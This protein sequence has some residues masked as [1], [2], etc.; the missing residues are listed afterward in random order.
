VFEANGLPPFAQLFDYGDGTAYLTITPPA[1]VGEYTNLEISVHDIYG[2]SHILPFSINVNSNHTPVITPVAPQAVKETNT[3]QFTLNATDQDNEA[4]TWS[5]QNVPVFMTSTPN[6]NNLDVTMIPL[7]NHA[8]TY[9]ITFTATDVN[10]GSASTIVTINVEDYDPNYTVN[11]NFRS[12]TTA[13]GP[14]DWN[15]VGN[16]SDDTTIPTSALNKTD[17]TS[18]GITFSST[19]QWTR[20]KDDNGVTPGVFPNAVN[21]SLFRI[22]NVTAGE[23]LTLVGLNPQGKYNLKFLSSTKL[24]T[25]YN[26]LA[27]TTFTI[28]G[29]SQ[30]I[31]AVGNASTLVTFSQLT[32]NAS[33]VISINVKTAS[34]AF[35][36]LNAMVIE[37]YFE[38]TTAP[39]A[40]SNLQ[41]ATT[42]A[43][44]I[45]V[46]W[47]DNSGG[48]TSQELYRSTDD[49]NFDKVAT[50]GTDVTSYIDT[51]FAAGNTYYYKVLA[52]NSI[53]TSAF[54]NTGSIVAP[55]RK[56]VILPVSPITLAEQD[57]KWVEV[58]G[59][60]VD[61]DALTF[62]LENEPNFM[63]AEYVDDTKVNLVFS[64]S[65]GEKGTYQFLLHCDDPNGG[66]TT[67]NLSVTVYSASDVEFKI[68]FTQGSSAAAPW[69]NVTSYTTGTAL[70]NLKNSNNIPVTGVSITLVQGWNGSNPNGYNS[71]NNSGIYPDAV[72]S[73]S[74]FTS[75]GAT[76]TVQLA[77]LNPAK[78][79]D[80]T[81][82]AS[83]MGVTDARNAIYTIGTKSAMLNA[84][85]NTSNTA[86]II[87]IKPNA[88]NQISIEVSKDG[89][90]TFGY[91]GAIVVREYETIVVPTVPQAPALLISQVLTRTSIKLD[92]Q[93]ASND[94]TGFEIW[95]S[96][97]NS[98]NYS[99]LTT[100]GAGV[101]TYT[102]TL[103]A[104][105]TST[106]TRLQRAM[107][108]DYLLFQMKPVVQPI[109]IQFQ[110]ISMPSMGMHQ[111]GII[112]HSTRK[113]IQ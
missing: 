45:Q 53:G 84:S 11:V 42:Q 26:N 95:R 103:L 65:L 20:F 77:G 59:T 27:V 82:F 71:G 22:W 51:N 43:D 35:A 12:F 5:V 89:A 33:G 57:M 98:T 109:S 7:T 23:T 13:N 17:G 6:G 49:I 64:P 88:S 63:W 9:N 74:F 21:S 75:D 40:P 16:G 104:T 50:L 38:G 58:T 113:V 79:Y 90:S 69:N 72:M 55:N 34:Q 41:V 70:N 105:S 24:N 47:T 107:Q 62:E 110:S 68:N 39:E 25:T 3:L 32:P 30:S 52:K 108:Q 83:R 78:T 87:G 81:F 56:P 106:F 14:A 96:V 28:S 92:W 44:A 100:V 91:L 86:K 112:L 15:N 73:G 36:I 8:G 85:G 54:S 19:G 1:I 18:S 76:K 37:S 31:N 99:L 60:D 67:A 61:G 93:D 101:T 4:I 102:N 29:Q 97:G 2:G 111:V 66:R 80:F 48:E 94:E 46:I 10:G